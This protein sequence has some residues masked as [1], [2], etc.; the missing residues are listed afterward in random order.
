VLDGQPEEIRDFLLRTSILE[1][2]CGPLCDA[3]VDGHGS[4]AILEDIERSNLFLVPLDTKRQWYRYHR[5][6]AELLRHELEL[7]E[8]G[9]AATLHRRASAWHRDEGTS[10]EAVHHTVAAGD[11]EEAGELI[12][13]H[14]NEFFNEGRLATVESWLDALG[15]ESVLADPRLCVARAWVALDRGGLD[16]AGGWIESAPAGILPGPMRDGTSSL[17]SAI[18]VLRA[19]HRFKIGD[20]RAANEAALQAL[21]LEPEG[22]QFGRVVAH[23]L[24]GVTLYW[25]GRTHEAKAAL[26]QAATLAKQ[27]DNKLGTVYAL[28]YLAV[29]HAD[30]A[31]LDRADE[32]ADE[33]LR[34]SDDPG[35]SEHFVTMLPHLACGKRRRQTG[36]IDE[37]D[38][39]IARAVELSRRGAGMLEIAWALLELAQTRRSEDLLR[40]A[41]RI[42]A[43][44][45]DPG[46]L[47]DLLSAAERAVRGAGTLRARNGPVAGEELSDRELDVLRLLPTRLSQREIGGSLYVSVNTVKTHTKSIFRKLGASNREE[48]VERARELGLL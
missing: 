9:L 3:V 17:E 32:L 26:E 38:Q 16:E 19:V 11:L 13:R 18:A 22:T 27:A 37:A 30:L 46:V 24:L 15:R 12:A 7:R 5:L 48:A 21:E 2:L 14:W 40:E 6:F 47:P 4:A 28:G 34:L 31:E 41:R 29:A 42:A 8:P 10:P 43:G 23:I 36:E 20:V 1:R 25:S 44:S 45:P 35:R 33:A 39:A